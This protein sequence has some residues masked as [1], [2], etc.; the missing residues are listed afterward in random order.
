[1]NEEFNKNISVLTNYKHMFF[2]N[3]LPCLLLNPQSWSTFHYTSD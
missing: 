2:S 1:M 3:N